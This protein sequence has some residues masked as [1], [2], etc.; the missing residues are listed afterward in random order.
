MVSGT[1]GYTRT[2]SQRCEGKGFIPSRVLPPPCTPERS[3]N[4][5]PM[6]S[7]TWVY[8]CTVSQRCEGK[9][10]IPPQRGGVEGV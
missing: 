6:V 7:G 10:Y 5:R 3:A 1:G 8:T 9:G 4:A 2:V